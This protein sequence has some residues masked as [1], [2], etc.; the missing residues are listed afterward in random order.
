[1]AINIPEALTIDSAKK[2]KVSIWLRP[3]GYSFSGYLP[4]SKSNFFHSQLLFDSAQLLLPSFKD[5]VF[6][7]TFMSWTYKQL[8]ITLANMRYTLIPNDL[9]DPSQKELLGK[10]AWHTS[11]DNTYSI[12]VESIDATLLL[13]L[14]TELQDFCIH[15]LAHPTFHHPI[16][17]LINYWA[18]ES[19]NQRGIGVYVSLQE[20]WMHVVVFE[21]G[22][23]K[24]ANTFQA[25]SL[26]NRLYYLLLIWKT[27]NLNQDR[28][29]MLLYNHDSDLLKQLKL[30]ILHTRE[31]G[32]PTEAFLLGN[33]VTHAPLDFIYTALCEL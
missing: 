13:Q 31:I 29:S 17:S 26:E 16:V 10:M 6:E 19:L 7:N 30:Y 25:S 24:F 3:D 8:S 15:T 9:Y 2:Y 28:D 1:M 23:M 12:P 33:E 21:K 18:T 32:L 11:Q 27:L 5:F 4:E 14:N 20:K 22:A